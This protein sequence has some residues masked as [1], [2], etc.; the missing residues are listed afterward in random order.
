VCLSKGRALPRSTRPDTPKRPPLE[1]STHIRTVPRC[2]T[3]RTRTAR[4]A[5]RLLPAQHRSS[6]S[7]AP[8]ATKSDGP[9]LQNRGQSR[10]RAKTPFHEDRPVEVETW[11]TRGGRHRWVRGCVEGSPNW[12]GGGPPP[13]SEMAPAASIA[14]RNSVDVGWK[15]R[16]SNRESAQLCACQPIER[17][18]GV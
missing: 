4:A 2:L 1:R 18:F 7:D 3:L 9:E 5:T 14:C 13:T 16:S 12:K 6:I 10:S 8:S 15:F 11:R 17:V